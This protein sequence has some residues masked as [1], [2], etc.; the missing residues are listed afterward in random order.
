MKKDI[1][2][3][4]Q[5]LPAI[6]FAARHVSNS[7]LSFTQMAEVRALQR[8]FR[9]FWWRLGDVLALIWR[10]FTLWFLGTR[11]VRAFIAWRKRT[12]KAI[13]DLPQYRFM[14]RFFRRMRER[15]AFRF[16]VILVL[17]VLLVLPVCFSPIEGDGHTYVISTPETTCV[18]NGYPDFT[19]EGESLHIETDTMAD[20]QIILYANQSVTIRKDGITTLVESRH[21]TVA[22][23]LRRLGITVAADEMVGVNVTGGY[24]LI[25]IDTELRYR[26]SE[27]TVDTYHT[28]V[29][30]NY[31]LDKGT[32]NVVQEGRPGYVRDVYEDVYRLGEIVQT[33]LIDRSDSTAVTQIVEYGRLVDEVERDDRIVSDHPYGGSSE[34]GYLVFA[35]GYSM[36]YSQKVTCNATAYYTGPKTAT[37][38]AVGLGIIAVDPK[39]FPYHTRMFIQTPSASRVYGIGQAEDCG[40]AVKGNIIDLWFPTLAECIRWG[41]RDVTCW[42]L[43]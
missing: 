28:K 42:V 22:N 36:T 43:D 7:W 4:Q 31:L 16:A 24:P 33:N 3:L 29:T 25:H 35:S 12:A 19:Y 26:R 6:K 8:A 2:Q 5:L 21:E 11:P 39:V 23:L 27:T 10:L 15:P 37:G 38:H 20:A 34:G 30:Y 41:R 13:H 40:G 17:A 1:Q 18:V 14:V 32:Y 9:L